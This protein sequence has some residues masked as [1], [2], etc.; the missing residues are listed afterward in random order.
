MAGPLDHAQLLRAAKAGERLA[1]EPQHST[2]SDPTRRRTGAVTRG[3]ASPARSGRPPRD[4]TAA[5]ALPESGWGGSDQVA[6]YDQSARGALGHAWRSRPTA[7]AWRRAPTT[8]PS[9]CGTRRRG[10]SSCSFA[11]TGSMSTTCASRRTDRCWRVPRVIPRCG[12]GIRFRGASAGPRARARRG[13]LPSPGP[14]R[15]RLTR[16]YRLSRGR[17]SRASR[18]EPLPTGTYP[19]KKSSAVRRESAARAKPVKRIGSPAPDHG[20]A[21]AVFSAPA[22]STIV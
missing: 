3:S 14:M 2:S 18:A 12:C 16:R 11:A 22:L 19:P 21:R 7:R 20:A 1:I 4:T 9:A 13:D 17:E 10:R 8:R 6:A 15:P 5:T